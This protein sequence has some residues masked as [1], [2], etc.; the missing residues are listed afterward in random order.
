MS[1]KLYLVGTPIGNLGDLSPRAAKTLAEADFVAAED[2][3]VTLRLLSHLGLKK[4]LVSYHDHNKQSAGAKILER[5]LGGQNCALCSDAGMPCISDPGQELVAL[6]AQNDVE[7]VVV[8]GPTAAVS[9][10]ALSGLPGGRFVFEGFLSVKKGSREKHL[11]AL[12]NEERTMIFYEAPHKLPYT[13][14]DMLEAFGDR[15]IAVCKELTKLYERVERTTLAQAVEY[16]EQNAPRGEYVLVIEGA[17]PPDAC[18]KLP[19]EQA[20]ALVARLHGDGLSLSD[21]AKQAAK[22]SG[23]KKGELYKLA[24]ENVEGDD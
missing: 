17:P 16:Y 6:C 19:L 4:S 15:N 5:L 10:L 18:E 23:H 8:P 3:R 7:V 11:R 24:L 22:Q 2:T 14:R 13:L 12:Q 20:L 9:A 21:A 1:G